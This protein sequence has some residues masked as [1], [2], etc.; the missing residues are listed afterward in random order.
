MSGMGFPPSRSS[1]RIG[2]WQKNSG[3]PHLTWPC[4]GTGSPPRFVSCN[5]RRSGRTAARRCAP[6]FFAAFWA[7]RTSLLSRP[8]VA[9]QDCRAGTVALG[10]S[11]LVLSLDARTVPLHRNRVLRWRRDVEPVPARRPDRSLARD[12]R[13][14]TADLHLA[15][16]WPVTN[17]TGPVPYGCPRS[18][19]ALAALLPACPRNP[20]RRSSRAPGQPPAPLEVLQGR[21]GP[22]VG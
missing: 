7:R 5:W 9:A 19:R 11:M 2:A 12:V 17:S 15:R 21:P 16:P 3:V 18:P 6:W 10:R 1:T 22:L 14:V 8:T 13:R 20:G 4:T